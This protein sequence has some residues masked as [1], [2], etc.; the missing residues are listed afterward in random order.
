MRK[1]DE[2]QEALEWARAEAARTAK[3]RGLEWTSTPP[4]KL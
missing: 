1:R 2:R 3:A 4:H